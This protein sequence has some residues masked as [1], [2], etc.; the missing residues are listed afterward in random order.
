MCRELV[1]IERAPFG[2]KDRFVVQPLSRW[3]RTPM[4][5]SIVLSLLGA[6]AAA[7]LAAKLDGCWEDVLQQ[8]RQ[9]VGSF[10]GCGP[11]ADNDLGVRAWVAGN[12]AG[13]WPPDR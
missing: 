7:E 4:N 11:D 8:I 10:F 12:L 6:S 2:E 13:T 9:L 1:L 5:Q 3:E